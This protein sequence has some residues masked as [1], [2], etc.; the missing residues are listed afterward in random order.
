MPSKVVG[1][2]RVLVSVVLLSLA[3]VVAWGAR[4]REK[5][6]ML[7]FGGL[8]GSAFIKEAVDILLFSTLS[9]VGAVVRSSDSLSE[10]VIDGGGE[11]AVGL[12]AEK[13]RVLLGRGSES[14]SIVWSGRGLVAVVGTVLGEMLCSDLAAVLPV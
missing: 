2:V 9:I 10:A 11:V 12:R 3:S 8:G 6:S 5:E 1:E 7:D 14:S 13:L 4:G